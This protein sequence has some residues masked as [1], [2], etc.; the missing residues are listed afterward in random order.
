MKLI[1]K[2]HQIKINMQIH[3]KIINN[4]LMPRQFMGLIKFHNNNQC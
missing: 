3:Y 1:Q 2:I 4:D